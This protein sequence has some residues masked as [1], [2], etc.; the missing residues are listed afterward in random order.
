MPYLK[1]YEDLMACADSYVL[2]WDRLCVE[3]ESERV[4]LYRDGKVG[5]GRGIKD[6]IKFAFFVYF[7]SP[8]NVRSVVFFGSQIFL[9]CCVRFFFIPN[10][11]LDVRDWHFT[12]KYVPRV[13]RR[14]VRRFFVSS[15][16]FIKALGVDEEKVVVSHNCWRFDRLE[17]DV[18][19]G[20]ISIDYI[21]SVRDVDINSELIRDI[22]NSTVLKAGYHGDGNGLQE[23][24]RLVGF[25]GVS[26]VEFTG[27]YPAEDETILYREAVI[28]NALVSPDDYNSRMLLPNRLYNAVLHTKP[29]LV[30]RGTYLSEV[31]ERYGLGVVLDEVSDVERAIVEYFLYFDCEEFA[32]RCDSFLL[33]VKSDMD[34]F[35]REIASI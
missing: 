31:V 11:Y 10:L 16:E 13:F 5:L 23:L 1:G 4:I 15:P 8:K 19:D 2:I 17:E 24:K 32:R 12:W 6:Y 29:L 18:R 34:K 7:N 26:N 20:P 25:L 22:K 35:Y 28:V 14:K 9:F 30:I 3:Q 21:G 27:E 33:A